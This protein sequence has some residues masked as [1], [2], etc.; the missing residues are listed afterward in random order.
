MKVVLSLLFLAAGLV[1]VKHIE[2]INIPKA[3]WCVYYGIIT[4]W[5]SVNH[6]VINIWD[7]GRNGDVYHTGTL[8]HSLY[9][10]ANGLPFPGG[11]RQMYGHFALF[12]KIPLMLFGNNMRTVGVTTAVFSGIAVLCLLLFL[13][14]SLKEDLS[15]LIGGVVVLNCFIINQL[16]LQTFPL[17]MFWRLRASPISRS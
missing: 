15:R 3:I 14:R 6:C 1:C 2:K 16:Y 7:T 10:V 11:L 8:Y 5:V 13:H 4:L 17:R 9:Y 12:Y